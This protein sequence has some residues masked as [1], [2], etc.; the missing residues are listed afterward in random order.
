[1]LLQKVQEESA[2]FNSFAILQKGDVADVSD[3]IG[4]LSR[5]KDVLDELNIMRL[6]FSEQKKVLKT[7]DGI[8]KSDTG[9]EEDLE[10]ELDAEYFEES[11]WPIEGDSKLEYLPPQRKNTLRHRGSV[12]PDDSQAG[13]S[14]VSENQ[15]A[16][17][18][19]G[20]RSDPDEFSYPLAMVMDSLEE[21]SGMI[22]RAEKAERAV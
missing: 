9:S 2:L 1:M 4:L 5:I 19:W 22:E 21:I 3:E 6:L 16:R 18:I 20:D 10:I 12:H 8:I 13:E 7:M 14:G 11:A 17:R 15:G